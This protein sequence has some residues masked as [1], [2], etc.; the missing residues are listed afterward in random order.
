MGEH[1]YNDISTGEAVLF[2]KPSSTVS[3]RKGRFQHQRKTMEPL[4]LALIA[5][6]RTAQPSRSGEMLLV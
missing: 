6:S 4:V 1:G 2:P 3:E 5:S